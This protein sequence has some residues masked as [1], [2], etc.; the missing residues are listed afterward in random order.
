[1]M[2]TIYGQTVDLSLQITRF[3][4]SIVKPV[5]DLELELKNCPALDVIYA[6]DDWTRIQTCFFPMQHQSQTYQRL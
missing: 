1:M 2:K 4:T 5:D 3:Q 6:L